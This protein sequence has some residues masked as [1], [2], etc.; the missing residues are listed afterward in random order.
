MHL[1]K[2]AFHA[3]KQDTTVK[4][5]IM[6][7][8]EENALLAKKTVMEADAPAPVLI[9][10]LVELEE[11]AYPVK[12]ENIQIQMKHAI[13]AK[14]VALNAVNTRIVQNATAQEV[15]LWKMEFA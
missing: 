14:E 12:M 13:P 5:A 15:I 9:V 8:Q 2:F 4:P 7:L 10:R 6:I 11:I 1:M 3:L